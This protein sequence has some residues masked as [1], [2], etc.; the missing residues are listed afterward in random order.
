MLKSPPHTMQFT[1]IE[2]AMLIMSEQVSSNTERLP[3][4]NS[5]SHGMYT[6]HRRIDMFGSHILTAHNLSLNLI[7]GHA[8]IRGLLHSL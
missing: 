3:G 1:L 4:S 5:V 6:E 7:T 2:L 8:G